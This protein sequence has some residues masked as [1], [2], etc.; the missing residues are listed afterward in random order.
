MRNWTSRISG[1]YGIAVSLDGKAYLN[2][3]GPR[4]ALTPDRRWR[5]RRAGS[6]GSVPTMQPLCF[7]V[8]SCR[9]QKPQGVRRNDWGRSGKKSSRLRTSL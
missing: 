6:G 8:A 3:E 7:I 5:L 4:S 9:C 1:H 2:W